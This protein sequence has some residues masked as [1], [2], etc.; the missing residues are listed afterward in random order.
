MRK[1]DPS[2]GELLSAVEWHSG[3][4]R[5]Y[6]QNS[7]KSYQRCPLIIL[8]RLSF[9][10]QLAETFQLVVSVRSRVLEALIQGFFASSTPPTPLP[11]F[12]L[13]VPTLFLL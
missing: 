7:E 6:I 11:F 10:T 8:N 4:V 9:K 2:H 3:L 1:A 5:S 12:L 13:H